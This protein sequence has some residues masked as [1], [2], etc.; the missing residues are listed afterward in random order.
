MILGSRRILPSQFHRELPATLRAFAAEQPWN[1]APNG[2]HFMDYV[3]GFHALSQRHG[4]FNT[5]AC[6]RLT[7]VLRADAAG[8]GAGGTAA[9]TTFI[10]LGIPADNVNTLLFG[11]GGGRSQLIPSHYHTHLLTSQPLWSMT[12]EGSKRWIF[13]KRADYRLLAPSMMQVS[14]EAEGASFN[15]HHPNYRMYPTAARARSWV[16]DV[17]EGEMII[18]DE[19]DIHTVA[20]IRSGFSIHGKRSWSTK[21]LDDA[22][23]AV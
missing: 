22:E 6:E 8:R 18:W 9:T 3:L 20:G 14:P 12:L 19:H 17:G 15:P 1:A 16:G 10:E 11:F 5:S 4:I 21:S 2:S 23:A 13:A 7:D